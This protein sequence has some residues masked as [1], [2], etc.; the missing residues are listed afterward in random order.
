MKAP[1]AKRASDALSMLLMHWEVVGA[2][3]RGVVSQWLVNQ[4][5]SKPGMTGRYSHTLE[6]LAVLD[7]N[8]DPEGLGW[9]PLGSY[10][11]KASQCLLY[12]E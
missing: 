7:E 5:F 3:G 1:K 4:D 10:P 6:S 11:T 12:H 2:G 8:T 9:A